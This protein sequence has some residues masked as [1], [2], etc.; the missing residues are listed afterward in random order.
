MKRR[1]KVYL[2]A[3]ALSA[4]V[5]AL[6]FALP[7]GP[8]SEKERPLLVLKLL[9]SGGGGSRGEGGA[10]VPQPQSAPPVQNV[11]RPSAETA[12]K[13]PEKAVPP[14]SKPRTAAVSQR[15]AIRRDP[16]KTE[17]PPSF[18]SKIAAPA[19]LGPVG[20]SVF[21]GSGKGEGG[22]SADG[23][24]VQ[25]AAGTMVLRKSDPLYP[26]P[27][28]IR[29]EQGLVSLIVTVKAGA[30][31]GVAVEK[32]SGFAAL[33]N[34]AVRALKS[35]RFVKSLNARVRIPVRFSLKGVS[36]EL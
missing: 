29:G 28:R 15:K 19:A 6:L 12:K 11:P 33:D 16:E 35:W 24:G 7:F 32:S 18:S 22:G 8:R 1:K 27:S 13:T 26:R 23:G 14:K 31:T 4:A 20:A 10:G 17:T 30:V 5:H 9:S 25:N 3:L 34:S 36:M 21:P 2:A